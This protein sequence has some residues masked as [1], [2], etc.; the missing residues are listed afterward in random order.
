MPAAPIRSL[1]GR[2]RFECCQLRPAGESPLRRR[3][4][5]L[6]DRPGALHGIG[7]A[8]LAFQLVA[9]GNQMP[10]CGGVDGVLDQVLGVSVRFPRNVPAEREDLA[11]VRGQALLRLE[12]GLERRICGEFLADGRLELLDL[13]LDVADQ[14]LR[15]AAGRFRLGGAPQRDLVALDRP[16]GQTGRFQLVLVL[17]RGIEEPPARFLAFPGHDHTC[18]KSFSL[19]AITSSTFFTPLSTS[20]CNFSI[21]FSPSSSVSSPSLTASSII[22]FAS[23]RSLRMAILCSS[24]LCL[25]SLTNSLRRSS[26]SGGI[27]TRT[28]SASDWALT[29]SPAALMAFSITGIIDFSQGLI[30]ISRGSAT[31]TLETLF[32]GDIC[33]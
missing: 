15:G 29:P 32:S 13:A 9:E 20:V 7:A 28:P 31:V 23:R 26:V 16:R 4:D 22:S 24:P 10:D 17:A 14:H 18:I 11:A 12:H 25:T 2:L 5:L 33:P 1:R 27:G 19:E 3:D 6:L 21:A 8:E 30:T